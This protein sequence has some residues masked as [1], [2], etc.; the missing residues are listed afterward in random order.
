[1]LQNERQAGAS[2]ETEM[3]EIEIA[4]AMTA[5]GVRQLATYDPAY[6]DMDEAVARIYRAMRKLDNR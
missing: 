3:D 2:A 6:E 5:A 1:M 4:A